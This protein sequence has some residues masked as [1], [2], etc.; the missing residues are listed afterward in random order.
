ML[1]EGFRDIIGQSGLITFLMVLL[2]VEKVMTLLGSYYIIGYKINLQLRTLV[3]IT[4]SIK[5]YDE[6]I[7]LHFL[8]IFYYILLHFLLK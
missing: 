5:T 6:R 8:Y 2:Y 4:S 1:L 7:L 3:H